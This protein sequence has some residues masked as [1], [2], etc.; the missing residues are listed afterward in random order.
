MNVSTPELELHQELQRF[1]TRFFDRIA[2][3]LEEL[4][5][6]ERAEVRDEALRKSALYAAAAMEIATGPSAAVNL[7]DMFVFIHLCR[8]VLVKHWIPTLYRRADDLLDAF[9]KA[10]DELASITDTAL[11]R[12]R[13]MELVEIVDAW[14]AENPNQTR[15]EGVRLADF[16]A[17]AGAAAQDRAIQARGLMSSVKTATE[18]ANQAMLLAERGMFLLHRMPIVWRLQVRLGA[19]E[20]LGDALER[21]TTGSEAASVARIAKRSATYAGLLGLAGILWAGR[22][23]RRRQ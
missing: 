2:Q 20:V 4:Q 12:R 8:T 9:V 17:A 16:S 19:R 5:A 14:I 1:T 11:D 18:A 21:V 23:S 6:S 15:V 7:L 10:E 22:R 13:R 3:G